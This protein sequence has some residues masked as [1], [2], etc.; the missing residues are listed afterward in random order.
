MKR[1]EEKEKNER[2]ERE[3]FLKRVCSFFEKKFFSS[4]FL[5]V[6]PLETISS[7]TSTSEEHDSNYSTTTTTLS[8][9]KSFHWIRF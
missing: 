2:E 5:Y 3:N 7:Y 8:V 6:T 4:F 1:G 9:L